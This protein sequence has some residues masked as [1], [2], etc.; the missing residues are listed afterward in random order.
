MAPAATFAV[1][2][3]TVRPAP[4]PIVTDTE[5]EVTVVLF[6]LSFVVWGTVAVIVTVDGVGIELGALYMTSCD[7]A[8]LIVMV[9][10]VE[11]PPAMLFT[12][13]VTTA[14]L[15][16]VLFAS[17]TVALKFSLPPAGTLV[18]LSGETETEDTI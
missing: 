16:T 12:N 3:I 17:V 1:A 15:S 7:P 14:V 5:F 11:F 10:I 18:G 9:P 2:G 4:L 6:P 8:V 13:Q